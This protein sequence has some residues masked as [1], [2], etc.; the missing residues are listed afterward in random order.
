MKKII[1]FIV[2][3]LLLLSCNKTWITKNWDYGTYQFLEINHTNNDTILLANF[4]NYQLNGFVKTQ[5]ILY[6]INDSHRDSIY[7]KLFSDAYLLNVPTYGNYKNALK[8]G[9]WYCLN[10]KDEKFFYE[11]FRNDTL[12]GKFQKL[13]LDT[14]NVI[15]SGN[16][17]QGKLNETFISNYHGNHYRLN[18]D[19][20]RLDGLQNISNENGLVETLI[21]D[22]GRLIEV[23]YSEF[24]DSFQLDK[25]GNG[26]IYFENTRP[27]KSIL[28]Y[29]I[30]SDYKAKTL[31]DGLYSVK[32]PYCGG[33]PCTGNV[34]FFNEYSQKIETFEIEYQAV[35]RRK[36]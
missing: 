8:D 13:S 2:C 34:D 12:H 7:Q 3:S 6:S 22:K 31:G 17:W 35:F 33:Y 10:N 18:Y 29:Q 27:D 26:F 19:K 5:K 16:Y 4:E 14:K 15:Y 11:N 9:E 21:F 28:M 25:N 32:I 1:L 36:I 20:G 30:I 23:K 24:I